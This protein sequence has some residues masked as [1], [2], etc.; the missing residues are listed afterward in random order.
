MERIK[1]CP[2][3]GQDAEFDETQI[4]DNQKIVDYYEIYCSNTE[5]EVT[6]AIEGYNKELL[7]ENWNKRP[8]A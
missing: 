8:D 6:V 7:I 5:C 1:C 3:C 2:F 4:H